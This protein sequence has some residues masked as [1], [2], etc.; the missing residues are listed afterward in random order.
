MA[1]KAGKNYSWQNQYF[2]TP[3]DV[4]NIVQE[5]V[6]QLGPGGGCTGG[7][8]TP[9]EAQIIAEQV[10]RQALQKFTP[11]SQAEV[12]AMIDGAIADY[13]ANNPVSGITEAQARNIVQEAIAADN[14]SDVTITNDSI[15]N[16]IKMK[17]EYM[18]EG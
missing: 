9:D 17:V 12:K 6:E 14:V 11:V 2:A 8:V 4:E 10:V 13:F 3:Y 7:G 5:I 18:V 1:L 15:S 16:G